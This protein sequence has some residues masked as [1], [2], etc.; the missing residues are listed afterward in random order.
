MDLHHLWTFW[1]LGWLVTEA[2]LYVGKPAH[3]D[4]SSSLWVRTAQTSATVMYSLVLQDHS[5]SNTDASSYGIRS[6]SCL[7]GQQVY[8]SLESPGKLVR[9]LVGCLREYYR[10]DLNR[11]C[12]M[13]INE[14]NQP[15][16]PEN[17][18][19]CNCYCFMSDRKELCFKIEV[20]LIEFPLRHRK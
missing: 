17:P 15:T 7:N 1:F 20:H 19:F 18:M 2:V 5:S 9:S 13:K 10:Y 6:S 14:N 3:L 16:L 4:V 11:G 8:T 12:K